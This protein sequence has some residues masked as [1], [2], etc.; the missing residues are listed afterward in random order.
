MGA[1]PNSHPL[2]RRSR[3]PR[4]AFTLIELAL[5]IAIIAVIATLV[6][7]RMSR[8][9]DRANDAADDSDTS[10]IQHAIELYNAEHAAYPSASRFSSQLARYT[11]ASGNVSNA[12]S[13]TYQ[14]G[15]YLRNEPAV[16]SVTVLG[17]LAIFRRK[18]N[19]TLWVYNALDGSVKL[20]D[21]SFP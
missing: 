7:V 6:A 10:A 12:K 1:T 16:G 20:Y 18:Q 13:T 4:P 21:F 15:P 17:S 5:T 9:I 11:D 2:P 3:T 19:G 8:Q 14:Y